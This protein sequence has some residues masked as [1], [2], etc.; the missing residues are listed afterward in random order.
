MKRLLFIIA[1]FLLLISCENIEKNYPLD[2]LIDDMN[3]NELFVYTDAGA[4]YPTG[5]FPWTNEAYYAAINK[6][7]NEFLII[8][9]TNYVFLSMRTILSHMNFKDQPHG[10][11]IDENRYDN[12]IKSYG[13]YVYIVSTDNSEDI[14]EFIEN[15]LRDYSL[16]GDNDE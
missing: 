15:K 13:P 10:L 14:I 5:R 6:D 9:E 2:E 1:A 3:E 12:V 7:T 16:D 4:A 8:K 11:Y